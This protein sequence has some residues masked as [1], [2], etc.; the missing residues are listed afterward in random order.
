MGICLQLLS[1]HFLASSSHPPRSCFSPAPPPALAFVGN[2]SWTCMKSLHLQNSPWDLRKTAS[3]FCARGIDGGF[4]LPAGR[5][6]PS[7]SSVRPCT[8]F[9]FLLPLI[10]CLFLP[11]SVPWMRPHSAR[12]VHCA[13][14]LFTFHPQTLAVAMLMDVCFMYFGAPMAAVR[15][16]VLALGT[17]ASAPWPQVPPYARLPCSA[18]DARS[19]RPCGRPFPPARCVGSAHIA[20][21]GPS[22]GRL[23]VA[24][25]CLL[26]EP[27]YPLI[28]L[29]RPAD[30]A[31]APLLC[32]PSR[33]SY[34]PVRSSRPLLRA[35]CPYRHCP[36]LPLAAFRPPPAHTAMR[37][38]TRPLVA[39]LSASP[40]C[41]LVTRRPAHLLRYPP[42]HI[43]SSA[44]SLCPMRH[45]SHNV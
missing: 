3:A 12:L 43:C 24:L 34:H 15:L 4:S 21:R 37:S 8:L 25:P 30:Y 7:A 19:P 41:T 26:A 33:P 22:I 36:A 28:A 16:R 1:L 27:L 18:R 31:A 29:F 9:L 11:S 10:M 17:L 38:A 13:H 5:C 44:C 14:T 2:M 23:L 6:F 32:P 39:P 42:R 35:W 20:I 40:S 45:R